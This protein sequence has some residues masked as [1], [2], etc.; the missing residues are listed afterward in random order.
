MVHF[1]HCSEYASSKA[2]SKLYVVHLLLAH[3]SN[4][5]SVAMHEESATAEPYLLQLISQGCQVALTEL[6]GSI[7]AGWE[8]LMLLLGLCYGCLFKHLH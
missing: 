7:C 3:A 8:C 6:Q 1:Q 2:D 4:S 5:R